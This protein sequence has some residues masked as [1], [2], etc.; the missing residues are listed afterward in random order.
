MLELKQKEEVFAKKSQIAEI[1]LR[2][3]VDAERAQQEVYER[4]LMQNQEEEVRDSMLHP[5]TSGFAIHE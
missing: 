5:P 1:E 3:K 2:A 4:A